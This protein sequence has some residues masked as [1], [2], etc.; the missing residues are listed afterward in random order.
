MATVVPRSEI[1][2]ELQLR[3]WR[4]RAAFKRNLEGWL[5]AS[6]WLIGFVIWTLVP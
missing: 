6:P 1:E 2:T 3:V 4:R 5:F